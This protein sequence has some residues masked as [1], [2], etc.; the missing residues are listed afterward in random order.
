MNHWKWVGLVILLGCGL[1]L[2]GCAQEE[3]DDDDPDTSSNPVLHL[4]FDGTG[5][6][7][8]SSANH[9]TVTGGTY[10]SDRNGNADSAYLISTRG[11]YAVA[12]PVLLGENH[13]I[14]AWVN[15]STLDSDPD[16]VIIE[17]SATDTTADYGLYA[18]YQTATTFTLYYFIRDSNGN[19][20]TVEGDTI[21]RLGTWYH[22]AG[23]YDGTTA[24]LYVN[25]SEVKTLDA[26]LTVR[27]SGS[28]LGVG[29]D[30]SGGDAGLTGSI[31]DVRIY[32][33]ALSSDDVK[34][35]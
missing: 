2:A 23:T 25:G 3:D 35:L 5:N 13:T 28:L 9:A 10:T 4:P 15:L 21:Y 7:Q 26:S 30:G 18:K 31:D 32:E 24:R 14:A 29:D 12:S 33:R 16:S 34:A 1:I 11:D 27:Q 22:V 8:S 6:D 19:A 20:Q 17:N